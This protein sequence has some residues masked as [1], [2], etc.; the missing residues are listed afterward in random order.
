M[1]IQLVN[2]QKYFNK[3]RKG[4]NQQIFAFY[5]YNEILL[6]KEV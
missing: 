5:F 1:H 4:K 6:S 3:L 2:G